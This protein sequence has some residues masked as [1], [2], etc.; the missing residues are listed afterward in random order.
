MKKIN[1]NNNKYKNTVILLIY[2]KLYLKIIKFKK[3]FKKYK[4]LFKNN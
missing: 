4:T 1:E 2:I 3:E